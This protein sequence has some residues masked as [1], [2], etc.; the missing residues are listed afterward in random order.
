VEQVYFF[1]PKLLRYIVIL[2]IWF[3]S[4]PVGGQSFQKGSDSTITSI[5]QSIILHHDQAREKV[6]G[7]HIF[8]GDNKA[9]K[10]ILLPSLHYEFKIAELNAK[11]PVHLE[12]NDQVQHFIELYLTRRWNELPEIIGLSTYYFPIIEEIL[13]RFN[14]PLELKYIAFVESGFDPLAVSSSGAI[15]LWQFKYNSGKMFDLRIDSYIDER[16]DA[17]K[18]TEAACRYFQYLYNTFHDWQLA[19]AAYNGGPGEIRNAIQRSGGKTNFWEISPLMAEQT[20]NYLPAFIAASYIFNNYTEHGINPKMPPFQAIQT[21]KVFINKEISFAQ[22]CQCIDITV[23]SL[24]WLNPKYKLGIIPEAGHEMELILPIALIPAF[25]ASENRMYGNP[26]EKE[27][28]HTIKLKGDQTDGKKMIFHVV[29]KGE[30]FHLIAMKYNCTIENIKTWNQ[31]ESNFLYP[32]QK[33]KIW[34]DKMH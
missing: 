31:L 28:Y 15:G 12:F 16:H 23:D 34:I 4:Y 21:E 33:L 22:V 8:A 24:R 18:S 32:G 30:F 2:F 1:K 9:G 29:E 19:I 10:P 17:I 6:T 5:N 20:R 7:T 13:N 11:T 3:I 14:L 26:V 25:I 27:N